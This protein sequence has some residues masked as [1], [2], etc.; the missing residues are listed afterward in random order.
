M[1]PWKDNITG[2]SYVSTNKRPVNLIWGLEA[3]TNP[4][5][6]AYW[7]MG[8]TYPV[9]LTQWAL[10]S[11]PRHAVIDQFMKNLKSQIREQ[12]SLRAD[13]LT[14]TGPAAVTKA[15]Q[16]W[17]EKTSDVRWNALTGLTDGGR[18][19]LVEDI[20]VFPITAFSPGRGRYGNMGSKP[21]THPDARLV[22]HALGSWRRFDFVVEY[23]KLCRSSFGLC[24][25]WSKV[26]S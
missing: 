21:V 17:L 10:A 16:M 1:A 7:R 23:G 26:P 15:T 11:A 22:H 18:S 5:T 13:P 25:E 8:Y 24:R 4:D 6:D 2:K 14:R 20:M 19:K 3:D 12:S 9:Q